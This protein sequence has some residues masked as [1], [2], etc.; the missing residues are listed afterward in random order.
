MR[1]GHDYVIVGRRTALT[2]DF[3][4]LVGE[5]RQSLV[6]LHE[7]RRDRARGRNGIGGEG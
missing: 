4:R 7:Q 6:R 3:E 2:V 1:S 5:L